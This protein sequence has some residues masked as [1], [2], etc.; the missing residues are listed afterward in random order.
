LKGN[1]GFYV[2]LQRNGKIN[3]LSPCKKRDREIIKTIS[4]LDKQH[5]SSSMQTWQLEN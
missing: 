2:K 1:N 3:F 4:F 5:T